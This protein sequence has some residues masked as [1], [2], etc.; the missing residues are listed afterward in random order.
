MDKIAKA[1]NVAIANVATKYILDQKA[2]GGVIVGC[3]L[4]VPG[5]NHLEQN[6]KT[7][8]LEIT[9][10]EKDNIE[11]II[12]RGRDLLKVIGDCGDEYR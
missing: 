6:L 8:S 4:G 9:P 3:R 12:S 1:H 5:A 10:T 2:V 11:K 7:F